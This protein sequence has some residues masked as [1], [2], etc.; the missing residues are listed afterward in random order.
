MVYVAPGTVDAAHTKATSAFL[1][2]VEIVAGASGGKPAT[3]VVVAP[4]PVPSL[5]V[6]VTVMVYED[7]FVSPVSVQ[8]FPPTVLHEKLPG[9]ATAVYV[10]SG[11]LLD[12][13]TTA[14]AFAGSAVS[15]VTCAGGPGGMYNNKFC[16][17]WLYTG[18]GL[19]VVAFVLS[20]FHAVV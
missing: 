7:P 11:I 2:L 6:P 20:Q 3:T 14:P 13:E 12:H 10:A 19:P 17:T 9:V 1:I 16:P 4:A 5:L 18:V 8:V 15:E